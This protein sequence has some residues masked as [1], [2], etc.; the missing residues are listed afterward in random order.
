MRIQIS[1][2]SFSSVLVLLLVLLPLSILTI[3][4]VGLQPASWAASS[5]PLPANCTPPADVVIQAPYSSGYVACGLGSISKLPAGVGAITFK[6]GDPNTLLVATYGK[7]CRRRSTLLLSAVTVPA[8]SSR[9]PPAARSLPLLP[10]LARTGTSGGGGANL[11]QN[12]GFEA[13]LT[14]L[15]PWRAGAGTTWQ[16]MSDIRHTGAHAL[17]LYSGTN[18]QDSVYQTITLPASMTRVS[19]AY[20]Y[21]WLSTETQANADR[22]C[23]ALLAPQ[24]SSPVWERCLDPAGKENQDWAQAQYTLSDQE[25]TAL[26]GKQL[27]IA[28]SVGTDAERFTEVWLDDV[29]LV[30]TP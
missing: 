15:T 9:S 28:V 11:V 26:K 4:S 19:V 30:V 23:V 13:S 24:A 29:S 25:L 2:V 14:A 18:G 27:E 21:K 1:G 20:W 22:V 3:G 5:P 7:R 16:V 17:N 6:Q 12:P 10:M 8:I